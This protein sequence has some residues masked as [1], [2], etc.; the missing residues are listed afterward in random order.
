MNV[1][2]TY[3][4]G[5]GDVKTASSIP[6]DATRKNIIISNTGPESIFIVD[7]ATS[8]TNPS[9]FEIKAGGAITLENTAQIHFYNDTSASLGDLLYSYISQG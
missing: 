4:V 7:T 5:S 8:G 2:N 1:S 9:G 6:E 3:S